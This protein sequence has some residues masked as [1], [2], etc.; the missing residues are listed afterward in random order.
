MRCTDCPGRVWKIVTSS[1]W[2]Q[3]RTAI[4]MALQIRS[5]FMLSAMA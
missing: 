2:G 5:V 3:R 4:S 1:W